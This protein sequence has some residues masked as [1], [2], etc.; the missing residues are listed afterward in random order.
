MSSTGLHDL[1]AIAAR[2]PHWLIHADSFVPRQELGPKGPHVDGKKGVLKT[3]SGAAK[4]IDTEASAS[5]LETARV[6]ATRFLGGDV[7]GAGRRLYFG[8]RYRERKRRSSA[9]IA[10]RRRRGVRDRHVI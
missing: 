6:A 1:R 5:W 8:S 9:S 4:A 10:R 7:G 3:T 2:K